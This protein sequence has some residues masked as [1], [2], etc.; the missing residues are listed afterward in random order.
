MANQP[1]CWCGAADLKVFSPD[2]LV[3]GDC[4]TLVA[5]SM[6]GPE[7]ARVD[8]EEQAFYGRHY[9]FEYQERELG[10]P[11]ITIRARSDLPERCLYWLRTILRYRLPPARTLDLGCGHGAFVML[12]SRAGYE[13]IGL[14][15]SPWVVEFSRK[16]FGVPVLQGPIEAQSL[17]PASLDIVTMMDVL[18]HLPDPVA[19][20]GAAVA[21]L[22]EDGL[23]VIQTPSVPVD[24]SW[25]DMVAVNHPFL[26]LMRERGHLYLFNETGLR[27]LLERAGIHHVSFEPAYF[28]AYDMFVV[29]SCR[30]LVPDVSQAVA[31]A[32]GVT[33][34]GRLV[35]ALLD[36]DAV[37]S[38]LRARY[39]HAERDRAARL[40]ALLDHGDRLM[41]A[42]GQV[43]ALRAE[44]ANFRRY[45]ATSEADRAARLAV[46]LEQNERLGA[47]E[48]DRA[49]RLAVIEELGDR[50]TAA[51]ADR[52]AR[53]AVINDLAGRLEAAEADRAARLAVINDL[54]GR[55]EAVEADRAARL[56]VIQE[57]G[58][59][60]EA[61]EADAAARI[62]LIDE[63]T[64]RLRAL[65][66]ELASLRF[67]GARVVVRNLIRQIRT[68][69]RR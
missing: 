30:P 14:E 55:L 63:Q 58:Q 53:L 57:L 5:A 42:E 51:E 8:D 59:R 47:A 34:D 7:I 9:W 43:N 49:A 66:A 12:L 15:L 65:D 13:A 20:L 67:R 19:T 52:A 45:L 21:A 41:G 35:Q 18:E 23:L 69:F 3:C 64:G 24:L 17:E 4:R 32:L 62:R 60:L 44:I 29:A 48:A 54:A 38:D 27:R 40:A 39:E 37:L 31:Q 28:G 50:L 25:N 16:T 33:T 11:D 6:P 36:L 56:V 68:V 10:T 2:Y 1:R 46:I 22:G 26:P 61:R